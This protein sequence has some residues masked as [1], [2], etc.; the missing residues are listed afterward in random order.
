MAHRDHSV[1]IDA[2]IQKKRVRVFFFH[3]EDGVRTS[4]LC[5]PMDYGP[6]R[7]A[8]DRSDRYHFWDYETENAHVMSRLP[9]AIETIEE[10]GEDFDPSE[11]VTWDLTKSPWFVTRNWGPFS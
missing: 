7:R 3:E 5:A 9:E 10:S 8:S 2:I 11:F 1:F 4:R 6:S